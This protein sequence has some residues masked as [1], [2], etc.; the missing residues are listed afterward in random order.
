MLYWIYPYFKE[1]LLHMEE[2]YTK[3]EI[4]SDTIPGEP[5]PRRRKQKE[6][7]RSR[8]K[9]TPRQAAPRRR[10]RRERGGF[11]LAAVFMA[12]VI[13]VMSGLGGGYYLWG[14]ERLN[15]VDLKAVEVPDWVEQDF[16][17]KNIFSRPDVGRS[18]VNNIVIHYVANPG[19]TAAENRDYFD[20]LADQDPEAGG[21]SASSHFVVGLEGE[22][23]QCIPVDEI[24]YA[25]APRNDDTI[26][27]EVCH[28]DDSGQF[29]EASY[30]SAVRLSAWLCR[31]LKLDSGDLLRHYDIN[32]KQC[33]KY[34]VEHEEAWKQFKSDVDQA[35]REL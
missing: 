13:G 22:V 21:T 3:E 7:P 2:D 23:I 29:N 10:E 17:R 19:S 14:W 15:T 1:R 6:I 32:G 16:I 25:N 35:I 28:P 27:I 24:A 26:S 4:L 9:G 34:Y 30:D 31:Q 20:S 5:V 11:P 8:R 33:P 18:Q 12:L